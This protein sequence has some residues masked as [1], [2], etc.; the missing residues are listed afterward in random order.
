[1]GSGPADNPA[2]EA[3]RLAPFLEGSLPSARPSRSL[4][5]RGTL[6]PRA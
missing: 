2:W 3:E 4:G 5:A 1:M 6:L